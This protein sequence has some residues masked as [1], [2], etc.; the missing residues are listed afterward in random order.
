MEL[1]TASDG[2]APLRLLIRLMLQSLLRMDPDNH[3]LTRPLCPPEKL[4]PP[5]P[6][7]TYVS[8]LHAVDSI[9]LAT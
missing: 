8:L 2:A 6:C 3:W 4:R 1:G 7:K 5:Y 9:M